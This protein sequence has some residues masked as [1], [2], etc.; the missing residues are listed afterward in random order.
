MSILIGEISCVLPLCKIT[1]SQLIPVEYQ[2]WILLICF[3][4]GSIAVLYALHL[5]ATD[6]RF[7]TVNTSPDLPSEKIS[8][9]KRK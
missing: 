9:G 3:V 5:I 4:I 2:G 6:I 8:K 1:P 7:E